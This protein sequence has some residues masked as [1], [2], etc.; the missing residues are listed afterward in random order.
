MGLF[1]TYVGIG[2]TKYRFFR[3][4]WHMVIP[5]LILVLE[6]TTLSASMWHVLIHRYEVLK[7][8]IFLFGNAGEKEPQHDAGALCL[9]YA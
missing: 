1:N 4:K 3:K 9:S 6:R 7:R 2:I 8:A 5:M